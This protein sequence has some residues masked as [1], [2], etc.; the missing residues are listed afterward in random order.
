MNIFKRAW[1]RDIIHRHAI[2][3]K[4]WMKVTSKLVLL[5]NLTAVEKA[6]LRE[7]STLFLH[8]KNFVGAQG[9][10]LTQAM[11]VN[12]AVQAC[13]PVLKLGFKHLSG[14]TDV[15]VY[16][17]AFR[18]SR[19]SVDAAGVVHHEEQ[20]LVGESWSRGPLIVSWAEIEQDGLATHA[21][22]NVVIH[23]T[24]HKL[25]VLNGRMNGFPPLNAGMS[26]P[27]WTAALSEAYQHLVTRV[28]HHHDTGI[29][30]YAASSPAEFF[31][32]AS[33]YFFCS[34]ETLQTQ[35]PEVYQQLQLYYRQNPLLRQPCRMG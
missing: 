12:I 26:A 9:L 30:P 17:T 22:R 25:D 27:E 6:H 33:E 18:I 15:I 14:W 23:E 24:A 21:G 31:A 19:D 16:P 5:H 11:T 1:L 34:P 28:G 32:V 35:F 20:V 13:L 8:E 3:H 2:P 10:D 7:L 29:D 4:L